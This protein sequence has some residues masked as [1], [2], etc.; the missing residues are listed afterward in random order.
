MRTEN[1]YHAYYRRKIK[2]GK[3][4]MVIINA[5]R[6]KLISRMFAVIKRDTPY[7]KLQLQ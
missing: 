3:H 1:E 5:I 7:V 6:N 4:H 2:E